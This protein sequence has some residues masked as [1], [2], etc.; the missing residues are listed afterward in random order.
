MRLDP[1][2]TN[3]YAEALFDLARKR[4]ITE[5]LARQ[6]LQVA[7]LVEEQPRLRLFLEAPHIVRQAKFDLIERVL[8]PHFLDTLADLA[9]YLVRKGRIE[10]LRDILRRL[11]Y[12]YQVDQGIYPAA[13]T[14]A[15]P[16][17]E[18]QKNRLLRTL[19]QFTGKR[20]LLSYKVDPTLLGGVVF[21]VQDTYIDDSL[22]GHLKRLRDQLH[23][24][25]VH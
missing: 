14:T 1:E 8:R 21:S 18:A 10:Y 4:G 22:R 7:A 12:L 9:I 15:L 25:K 6:A 23:T 17:D 5:P 20:L 24:V 2:V 11:H 13:L 3:V 16:L 19:E